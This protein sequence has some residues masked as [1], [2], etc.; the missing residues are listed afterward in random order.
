M[1]ISI[2]VAAYNGEKYLRRC[3][4]S[5]CKQ[6][7]KHFELIL[8]NDCSTDSTLDIAKSYIKKISNYKILSLKKNS[9]VSAAR[10]AGIKQATGEYVTFIDCDDWIEENAVEIMY[11]SINNL[12]Q[13]IFFEYCKN[14]EV[15]DLSCNHSFYNRD[16][17]LLCVLQDQKVKGYVWTKLF[18]KKII[19]DNR[20][21]FNKSLKFCE[22]LNFTVKYIMC[23][24]TVTKYDKAYYHYWEN[25]GSVSKSGGFTSAKV[26]ALDAISEI[27]SIMTKEKVSADIINQ[28]KT[29]YMN[30]LL[31]LLMNGIDNGIM[32]DEQ[33]KELESLLYKYDIKS[34]VSARVKATLTMCRL[35][36]DG[37]Y[38]I[39]R[40]IK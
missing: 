36:V 11:S 18:S 24:D 30:I 28:Y 29:Y 33:R 27:I 34:I 25:S 10:N 32:T 3:L 35:S 26:T 2:I 21:Y 19:D 31:S 14:N 16:Q 37:F 17:A 9:G 6:T 13:A 1:M 22:D 20:I 5:L 40:I 8:V 12:S 4:D 23:C 7:N 39:W 15:K 38:H